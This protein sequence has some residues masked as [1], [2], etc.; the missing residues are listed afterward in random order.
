M[1]KK[2]TKILSSLFELRKI[3]IIFCSISIDFCCNISRLGENHSEKKI[4]SLSVK[5]LVNVLKLLF[6]YAMC[7]N[8]GKSSSSASLFVKFS[9]NQN[10]ADP[11]KSIN[12]EN[13]NSWRE[14]SKTPKNSKLSY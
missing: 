2:C 1:L 14:N 13:V 5:N 10:K 7:E 4:I 11:T 3:F 8:H 6:L 12:G 9:R